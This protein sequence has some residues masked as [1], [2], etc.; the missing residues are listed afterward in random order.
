VVSRSLCKTC[1]KWPLQK[2]EARPFQTERAASNQ[3]ALAG[4]HDYTNQLDA[5]LI[6]AI[7]V[8]QLR[9]DYENIVVTD[10][11]PTFSKD[12]AEALLSEA[13]RVY[14][15]FFPRM[16]RKR[17]KPE[18]S[19]STLR[20]FKAAL[21]QR[22]QNRGL[23]AWRAHGSSVGSSTPKRAFCGFSISGIVR[24]MRWVLILMELRLRTSGI[25]QR[26]AAIPLDERV[27]W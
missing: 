24:R 14:A 18:S 3:D 5:N 17:F 12:R 4:K 21:G 19:A 6:D 2:K 22:V 1:S 26:L 20:H 13:E 16:S 23:I 7:G 25:S 8:G 11:F 10:Y 27:L 15:G 9:R